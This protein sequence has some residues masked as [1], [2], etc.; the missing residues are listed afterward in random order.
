VKDARTLTVRDVVVL[1]ILAE[2]PTYGYAIEAELQRRDVRDWAD[3]SRPQVYK[4]L[5]K[6][7]RLGYAARSATT[8][9][10]RGPE[11]ATVRITRAGRAALNRRL[12]DEDWA[13]RRERP[14]FLTWLALCSHLPTASI[15]ACI[16]ARKTFL[17]AQ[18][19]R[20]RRTLDAIERDVTV[21]SRFP[22]AMVDL[23][24]RQFDVELAWL[25]D[26]CDAVAGAGIT[27]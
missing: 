26:L 21:T 4:S 1:S 12:A 8:E 17:T 13:Q 5:E 15:L 7:Q 6:L 23:A 3:I 22:Q 19:A 10:S 14:L 2:A 25:A 24:I 20:E 16:D 27:R 11:S 18:R 9:S